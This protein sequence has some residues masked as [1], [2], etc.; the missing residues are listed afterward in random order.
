VQ[1]AREGKPTMHIHPN[2]T[3]A[4]ETPV[5]DGERVIAYFGMTGVYC[6]DLDGTLVWSKDLGAYPMQFGWGTGSSLA[7]HHDLV[8][9]QCD[10]D[11]S[12]F[13]VALD[14]RTGDEV[15]RATRTERS[16]WSTPIIWKNNR[17]TELVTSGGGRMRSYNPATGEL[18]WEM[19]ASGRS[20]ASPVGT[21]DLLYVDSADRLTGRS[22]IFAALR[23]GAEG[24]ISPRKDELSNPFV[25]WSV[26]LNGN[27]IASPLVYANNVY[28]LEQHGGILRC[29]DAATGKEHFRKRLPGASGFTSS[30]WASR[31]K[32]FCLDQDGLTLVIDPGPTLQVVASNRLNEMFWSS[33]AVAGNRLLLRGV[34]HLYCVGRN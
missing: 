31:G 20:A 25:A 16:N 13:L 19:R 1:T 15:W 11:R 21:E 24:D 18:L 29:F 17:R 28:L 32:I 2:N 10:N 33:V 22:G 6:Y 4:S 7:L 3:Y 5:T 30:P 9:V 23:A 34:D 26:R 27:R 14:K 12:S 8:F